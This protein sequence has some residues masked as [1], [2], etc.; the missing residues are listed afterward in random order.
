MLNNYIHGEIDHLRVQLCM[1]IMTRPYTREPVAA[2][3]SEKQGA[4]YRRVASTFLFV[5]SAAAAAAADVRID[6]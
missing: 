2:A 6:A 4:D 3:V 5:A 1:T